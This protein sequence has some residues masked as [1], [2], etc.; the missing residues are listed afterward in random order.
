MIENSR[1]RGRQPAK[2]EDVKVSDTLKTLNRRKNRIPI[3]ESKRIMSI[4]NEDK[5]LRYILITDLDNDLHDY[6]EGGY[7]FVDKNG[8][9]L[10]T[11]QRVQDP[12]VQ[13]SLA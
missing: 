10:D 11:D 3:T 2:K 9:I 8:G 6:Y 7:N 13:G 4:P 12:S 5:S 1:K